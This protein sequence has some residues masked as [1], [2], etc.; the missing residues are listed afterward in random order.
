MATISTFTGVS[1][2]VADTAIMY[3]VTDPSGSPADVKFTI[4]VL[5]ETVL[6]APQAAITAP[7]GGTTIDA[8]ARTAIGEILTAL[9]NANILSA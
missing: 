7:S 9:T 1:A 5:R 2:P 8:E 4:A 3:G 6:G